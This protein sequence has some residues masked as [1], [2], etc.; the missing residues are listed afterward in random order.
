M[1]LLYPDCYANSPQNPQIFMAIRQEPEYSNHLF[2][3]FFNF[4]KNNNQLPIMPL[5]QMRAQNKLGQ[6]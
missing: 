3:K 2:K 5:Y 4:S 6:K 1:L